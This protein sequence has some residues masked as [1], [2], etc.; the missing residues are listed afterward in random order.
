MDATRQSANPIQHLSATNAH[1]T[2]VEL[3]ASRSA[4]RSVWFIFII[5]ASI[6]GGVIHIDDTN[7]SLATSTSI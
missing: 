4:C 1:T 5:S 3:N 2:S 6:T 7:A